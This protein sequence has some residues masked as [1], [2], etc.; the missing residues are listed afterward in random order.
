MDFRGTTT[1]LVYAISN[2]SDDKIKGFPFSTDGGNFFVSIL[3]SFNLILQTRMANSAL[4]DINAILDD[5]VN[6]KPSV[7]IGFGDE[8]VNT[9][10]KTTRMASEISGRIFTVKIKD[11]ETYYIPSIDLSVILKNISDTAYVTEYIKQLSKIVDIT[12]G[13]YV[14]VLKEKEILSAHSFEEFKNIY[15]ER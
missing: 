6:S 10:C 9:F 15:E 8:L 11:F 3:G 7:I 1:P 14:D 12:N 5:I 2:N 4:Q 13:T